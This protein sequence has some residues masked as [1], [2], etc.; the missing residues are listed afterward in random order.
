[1]FT[2]EEITFLKQLWEECGEKLGWEPRSGDICFLK[3]TKELYVIY[4]ATKHEIDMVPLDG[5]VVREP[6][7]FFAHEMLAFIPLFSLSQ[8]LERLGGAGARWE[9]KLLV[10]DLYQCSLRDRNLHFRNRNSIIAVGRAL[11]E[12][13]GKEER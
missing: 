10:N 13:L 12:M 8:L 3:T 11:M 9:L 6:S 2:P 7:C 4:R 5:I 1:M